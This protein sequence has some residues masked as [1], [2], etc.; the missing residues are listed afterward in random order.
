MKIDADEKELLEEVR[1]AASIPGRRPQTVAEAPQHL[2]A[3]A[4]LCVLEAR[5]PPAIDR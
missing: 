4:A 3:R 5:R 1:F 2:G